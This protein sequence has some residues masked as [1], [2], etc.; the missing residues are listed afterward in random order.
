VKARALSGQPTDA[1]VRAVAA[2]THLTPAGESRAVSVRSIYRW[3]AEQDRDE[4]ADP[5]P[6]EPAR[7]ISRA[8]PA[9]LLDFLVAEKAED[10]YSCSGAS[11]RDRVPPIR[12]RSSRASIR[13]A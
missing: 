2:Q 7:V 3:L 12:A 5:E 10:R 4:P 11:R 9:A 8:L 6:A 13:C 1:A